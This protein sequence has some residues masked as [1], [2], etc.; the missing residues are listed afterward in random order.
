M[1]AFFDKIQAE[2]KRVVETNPQGRWTYGDWDV[3]VQEDKVI[4]N[5]SNLELVAEASASKPDLVCMK[6]DP[7]DVLECLERLS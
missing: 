3:F 4:I 2:A 5:D 1:Q 6:C 7:D